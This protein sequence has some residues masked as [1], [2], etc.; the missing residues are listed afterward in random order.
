MTRTKT[1]TSLLVASLLALPAF[2][3]AD[4]SAGAAKVA[5]VKQAP[6]YVEIAAVPS[7]EKLREARRQALTHAG[8]TKQQVDKVV[9]TLEYYD[10]KRAEAEKSMNW[11]QQKLDTLVRVKSSNEAAYKRYL[12]NAVKSRVRME[13]LRRQ[14]MNGL[15]EGLK[16][17]QYAKYTHAMKQQFA[18]ARIGAIL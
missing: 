9:G 12:D 4:T 7:I 18:A 13:D 11:S 5:Q 15:L 2:A 10:R 3:N 8:L 17:S 6:T 1:L 16:P 14:Q